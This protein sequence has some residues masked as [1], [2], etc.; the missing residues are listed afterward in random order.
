MLL[1]IILVAISALL[2]DSNSLF[3]EQKYR[4]TY[5][6]VPDGKFKLLT[7]DNNDYARVYF[8]FNKSPSH[9]CRK[10]LALRIVNEFDSSV[11]YHMQMLNGVSKYSREG[12]ITFPDHEIPDNVSFRLQMVSVECAKIYF[13]TK[14]IE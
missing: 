1:S 3:P 13:E 4:K 2:V 14:E 10:T 9:E 8:K 7:F 5:R 11:V 12:E 6:I